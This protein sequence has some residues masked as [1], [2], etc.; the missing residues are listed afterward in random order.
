MCGNQLLFFS[1]N[2]NKRSETIGRQEQACS[3][4]VWCLSQGFINARRR[5]PS[6]SARGRQKTLCTKGEREM[7]TT[8]GRQKQTNIFTSFIVPSTATACRLLPYRAG[9]RNAALRSH[10]AD[11]SILVGRLQHFNMEARVPGRVP[12]TRR[13]FLHKYG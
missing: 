11:G 1:R 7:Q 5:L 4:G 3:D 13:S 6:N 12:A 10:R 2:E 9:P 8:S